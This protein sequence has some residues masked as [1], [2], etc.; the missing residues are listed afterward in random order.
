MH[1]VSNK[2]CNEAAVKLIE[3]LSQLIEKKKG[4]L[5]NQQNNTLQN[6]FK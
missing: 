2:L 3:C 1:G 4:K 6:E 5:L